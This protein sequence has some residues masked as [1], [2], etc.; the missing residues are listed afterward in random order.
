MRDI[1]Q[2]LQPT[3]VRSLWKLRLCSSLA[4]AFSNL[5]MRDGSS[6]PAGDLSARTDLLSHFSCVSYELEFV[7]HTF[8]TIVLCKI[9]LLV[10]LIF[11]Y[12]KYKYIVTC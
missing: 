11:I 4:T 7:V 10:G 12:A 9:M 1:I 5:T 2:G 3:S 8:L 6:L